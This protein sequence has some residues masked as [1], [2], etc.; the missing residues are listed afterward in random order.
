ML[1]DMPTLKERDKVLARL[2]DEFEDVPFDEDEN[3]EM[4]LS[5]D[6]FIFNA[7]TVREDIWKWFDERYS[8]G[9][10]S[11]LHLVGD[12]DVLSG[13]DLIQRRAN[14]FECMSD[15]CAFNPE[16]ICVFPILYNKRPR[17]TEED[18]CL[19]CTICM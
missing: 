2:W 10:A 16:G 8:T 11:L 18:G 13:R 15:V 19:D 7:G 14:C 6:W 12:D 9:V 17:V 4:V 5:G 1:A 3:G